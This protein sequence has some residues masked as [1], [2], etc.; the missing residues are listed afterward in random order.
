MVF[1]FLKLPERE[2]KMREQ[3][4]TMVLDKGLGCSAVGDLMVASEWIDIVKLGWGTPLVLPENFL[5]KKIRIYK[6]NRIEVSNGGT[7]LEFAHKQGKVDEFLRKA[8][9]IG[10]TSIE[11]S[12]G[13]VEI[14]PEEKAEIIRR[15][16][17]YGFKVYS[18]VGKK[19]STLDMKLSLEQRIKEAKNDLKAGARKV[20]LEA[21][22]SGKVG[23][24]DKSGNVK[25][26]FLKKLVKKIGLTNVIFEAPKKNQQVWL[27]LTF[28]PEVNLGNI[29]PADV[30]SLE[31]LRKGLRGDTLGKIP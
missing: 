15:S 4:I 1:D 13:K 12:N 10:L 20:I 5:K 18:E 17:T 2:R 9:T 7:L 16:R 23:I 28:G 29:K 25:E 8:K 27:I 22:E 21:R 14:P 24:Y 19:D 11:V 6:E 31:T 30:I 3:G 26:E